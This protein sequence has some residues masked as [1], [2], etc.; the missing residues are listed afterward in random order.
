MNARTIIG[1]GLGV[2]LAAAAA[3]SAQPTPA[4]SVAPVPPGAAAPALGLTIPQAAPPAQP[5]RGTRVTAAPVIPGDPDTPPAP[6]A[7]AP[8]VTIQ[9]LRGQ[10]VNVKVEFT[11]TEQIGAK[12]PTRKTMTM[13]VADRENGRIRT[14]T[15]FAQ[16]VSGSKQWSSAPLSVDALPAVEGNKIRLD[17][18]LEYNLYQEVDPSKP[19]GTPVGKTSVSERLSAVLDNGVPLVIAQSSDALSDRR[20]TVEVKATIL[21]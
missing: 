18:S 4:A 9:R 8:P 6:A 11:I 2:L 3:A 20:L 1:F 21:K 5:P 14:N 15:D 12:P 10:L 13:T 16:I 7:Q 19:E 17:F